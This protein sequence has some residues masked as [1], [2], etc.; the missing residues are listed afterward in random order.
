MFRWNGGGAAPYVFVPY[1]VDAGLGPYCLTKAVLYLYDNDKEHCS[2]GAFAGCCMRIPQRR[3]HVLQSKEVGQ[4]DW[5]RTVR[6]CRLPAEPS[7]LRHLR[8]RAGRSVST[9]TQSAT[10]S[11]V[12]SL[13]GLAHAPSKRCVHNSS[14]G[15]CSCDVLYPNMPIN[16]SDVLAKEKTTTWVA[17]G[18]G[19]RVM[20]WF[21]A[22]C[23]ACASAKVPQYNA[24]TCLHFPYFD[25]RQSLSRRG[26][27]L[28]LLPA[29][30]VP[31]PGVGVGPGE[32]VGGRVMAGVRV[33]ADGEE[34]GGVRVMAGGEVEG[35]VPVVAVD[36]VEGGVGL[37][38]GGELGGGVRVVA[39]DVPVVA[40]GEV[41]GGVGLVVGGELVG[42]V[43]VVAGDVALAS[44]KLVL[45]GC[46]GCW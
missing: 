38:M 22:S 14:P 40:V 36:E 43:R 12:Q 25:R 8:S 18:L 21:R 44:M 32:V 5:G 7:T 6:G 39:G 24:A 31:V 3:P 13:C 35:D 30:R 28:R 42:G 37:V 10:V 34:K 45:A 9:D 11:A 46:G 16:Q 4:R 26:T 19:R 1:I 15:T 2:S 41:E 17:Q 29:A 20:H 33:V 27:W 23:E